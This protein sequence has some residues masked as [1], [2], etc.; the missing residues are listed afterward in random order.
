M[1]GS[2]ESRGQTFSD[3]LGRYTDVQIEIKLGK[4]IM[5]RRP[6]E[7]PIRIRLPAGSERSEL[8]YP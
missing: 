2:G 1:P 6:H 7:E 4:I 3:E 5:P 8:L